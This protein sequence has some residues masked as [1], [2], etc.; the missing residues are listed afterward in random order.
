MQMQSRDMRRKESNDRRD[1]RRPADRWPGPGNC[2]QS[3]RDDRRPGPSLQG[4]GDGT[5][6]DGDPETILDAVRAIEDR[7]RTEGVDR[8]VIELR[9]LLE[10][11]EETLENQVEG[12]RVS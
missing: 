9:L 7:L 10:P 8:A 11:H 12:M 2:E 3:G 4:R 1:R 6:V 5:S